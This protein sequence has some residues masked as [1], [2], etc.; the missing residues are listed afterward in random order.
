MVSQANL[1]GF[2]ATFNMSLPGCLRLCSLYH[3]F[4]VHHL[5]F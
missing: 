3:I 1:L 4:F 2:C 5:D